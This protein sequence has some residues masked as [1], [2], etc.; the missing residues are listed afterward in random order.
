MFYKYLIIGGGIAGTTAAETI[1]KND[2]IGTIAIVEDEKY[3]LYS[4]LSLYDYIAN[5]EYGEKIFLRKLEDYKE[6][7]IDL[8]LGVCAQSIDLQKREAVFSDGNVL[9]FE[10][11]LIAS[12]GTPV[13]PEIT[14]S[15]AM[16]EQ[17]IFYYQN[18]NDAEKIKKRLFNLRRVAVLGASFA[19]FELVEL[20]RQF[21]IEVDM[22]VRRQFLGGIIDEELEDYIKNILQDKKVN[23]KLGSSINNIEEK[24]NKVIISCG[25]DKFEYDGVA[26]TVGLKRNIGIFKNAGINCA[27]GV[28]TDEYLKTNHDGAYAAGD[29]AE[30][31]DINEKKHLLS[32]SWT[33]AF[34]QGKIAGENMVGVNPSRKI[35]LMPTY[36]CSIFD[37][38]FTFLGPVRG[39]DEQFEKIS[40]NDL[41]NGKYTIL[42]L[43]NNIVK[44]AALMNSNE[45]RATLN[46]LINKKVDVG[47]CKN[48]LQNLEFKL[49]S[50]I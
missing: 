11:L 39:L 3:P 8:L 32:G 48:D 16:T 38:Q 15:L 46:A 6:K 37:D 28:L 36:T 24:E 31:F 1:R 29:V 23:L 34:M 25:D 5:P 42:Y 2:P 47:K 7:N 22:F 35:E 12:G 4:R 27:N 41:R 45:K 17:N 10:K 14:S 30:Y 49:E 44:G 40:R 13:R 18:L 21:D 50:M 26:I 9:R 20:F 43:K 19:A 33:G